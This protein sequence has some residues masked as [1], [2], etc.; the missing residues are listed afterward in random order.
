M[1]NRPTT[2][3]TCNMCGK[4]AKIGDRVSFWTCYCHIV[5]CNPDKP[6]KVSPLGW[7]CT[8]CKNENKNKLV[9]ETGG[10]NV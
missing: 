8:G 10:E 2:T 7:P 3:V 4:E 9:S 1:G 6:V 5:E